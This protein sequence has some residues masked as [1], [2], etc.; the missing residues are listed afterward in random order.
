[1]SGTELANSQQ[2]SYDVSIDQRLSYLPLEPLPVHH[3]KVRRGF[4]T[5]MS[6]NCRSMRN[7]IEDITALLIDQ[8]MDIVLLQETWLNKGDNAIKSEIADLKLEMIH[9]NRTRRDN[10]GGVAAIFKPGMNIRQSQNKKI[11]K[12]F[13]YTSALKSRKMALW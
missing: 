1:M 5:G 2:L 10:G 12:S 3:D 4:G 6:F 11:Y 13:E 9:V 7:K 8:Q